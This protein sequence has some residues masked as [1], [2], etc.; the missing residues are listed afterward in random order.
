MKID[1]AR[2]ILQKIGMPE[3]QQNDKCCRVLL[4]LA[5]L[6]EKDKWSNAKDNFLRIH[7]ILVFLREKYSITYAENTRE[8]I[9][10]HA[11]KPFRDAAMVETNGKAVN[12]PLF[13]Y[14]LTT[15]FLELIRTYGTEDWEDEL[16]VFVEA[17]KTLKELYQQR[18]KVKRIEVKINGEVA[19][20]SL[21]KHNRLQK[22]IIEDFGQI[23]AP[24]SEVIYIGDTQDKF[25]Y[26]NEEMLKQLNINLLDDMKLPDIIL[27]MKDKNW[28]FFIEAVTSV[29]PMTPARVHEIKSYCKDTSAGLIFVTA[30]M[31]FKTYKKFMN[32]IAWDTEVWI[33]ENPEHM[34]HLNG[35]RFL[36][37]RD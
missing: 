5:G 29:G 37:P 19:S 9:R 4:A 1:D 6:E 20:L 25:L 31:N 16:A 18:K 12:S 8:D 24:G 17:H 14:R 11:I 10:K 23:F 32:E 26:K 15:E 36:G 33:A 28:L 22:C 2:D 30:F 13:A 3:K 34:I 27:Y 35:D 21:G 7:D